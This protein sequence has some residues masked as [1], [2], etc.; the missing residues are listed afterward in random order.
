MSESKHNAGRLSVEHCTGEQGLDLC[1]VDRLPDREYPVAIG[2]CYEGEGDEEIAVQQANARRLAACWNACEGIA[3][4]S[5]VKGL[6][7]AGKLL[8][9]MVRENFTIEGDR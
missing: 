5:S 3:D 9:E 4:V 7:A 8:V 1:L 2:F 6:L